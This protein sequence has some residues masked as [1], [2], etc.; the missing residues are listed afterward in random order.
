MRDDDALEPRLEFDDLAS[1]PEIIKRA[2]VWLDAVAAALERPKPTYP[3]EGFGKFSVRLPPALRKRAEALFLRVWHRPGAQKHHTELLLLSLIGGTAD[4]A[5]I[6]FWREAIALSRVR[7]GIATQRRETAAQALAFMA[8]RYPE[9]EAFAVLSD[10][11]RDPLAGAAVGAVDALVAL[12][13][14]EELSG[15]LAAQSAEVL[16]RV[17]VEAKAF[18][19]RFLA[20]RFL[21]RCGEPMPPYD[22]GNVI[23]FEVA[24]EGAR[25]TIE[26]TADE[27][28][29]D[30]HFAIQSA[31]GWDADHVHVFSLVCDFKDA[32]FSIP[33]PDAE[34]PLDPISAARRA[35]SEEA[36]FPLGAIELPVGHALT[37]LFDLGD[38]HFFQVRVTGI[39]A[40]TPRAKYPRVTA[41]VGK[42]PA[43]YPTY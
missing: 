41:R 20:R 36:S 19:P 14:D 3:Y 38:W 22:R 10:L 6:P 40:R 32:R 9:S 24:F 15:P 4:P 17:A 43:Q 25:R 13:D 33:G 7:D 28:L 42:A 5:S 30:L 8:L 27:T 12:A 21:L 26:L 18:A 1:S 37:Y 31:F 23:V 16:R 39:H 34:A 29:G 11:T 2:R 35:T